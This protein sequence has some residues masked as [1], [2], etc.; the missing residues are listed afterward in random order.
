MPEE[1][2]PLF[3]KEINSM[4]YVIARHSLLPIK[5]LKDLRDN[6]FVY[7]TTCGVPVFSDL[8]RE[9]L[10]KYPIVEIFIF[11]KYIAAEKLFFL[12]F[13]CGKLVMR[14]EYDITLADVKKYR[15]EASLL[16]IMSYGE[17]EDGKA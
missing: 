16:D 10:K 17:E 7:S 11:F 3:P 12:Y 13:N 2:N 4:I 14:A 5:D 15:D 9:V 1:E 6:A 8:L